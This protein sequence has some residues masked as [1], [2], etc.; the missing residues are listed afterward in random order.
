MTSYFRPWLWAFAL[1]CAW[2]PVVSR[3]DYQP[4][5]QALFKLEQIVKL[6]SAQKK[7]AY[8]IFDNL[9][10]IMDSMSPEERG[11]KGAQS[12]HDALIAIRSILT[13]DQQAIYDRTPQRLGGGMMSAG[14][15]MDAWRL[16]IRKLV[17]SF[18]KRSSAVAAEFGGT[19]E[20]AGALMD[21]DTVVSAALGDS[22]SADPNLHPDRGSN[23]VRVIGSG[24][25][26]TIRVYWHRDK[27]DSFERYVVDKFEVV[28]R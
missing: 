8:K 11:A 3:A 26:G 12:R 9:K 2:L 19:V 6:T 22:E 18:A 23:L 16:K 1:T 27:T 17:A 13:P 7:E 28:S 5:D 20:T 4:P 21:G 14:P 10:V 25:K 15:A 24:G